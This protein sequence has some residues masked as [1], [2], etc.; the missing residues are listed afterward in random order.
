ME[1]KDEK[2][3]VLPMPSAEPMPQKARGDGELTGSLPQ[4]GFLANTYLPMQEWG[5]IYDKQEAFAKGT[6]FPGLDLPFQN[7]VNSKP[8]A[9]PLTEL[10][11]LDF[12][13]HELKLY[14]DVHPHDKEALELL[15]SYIKMSRDAH[16]AFEGGPL[17]I[18][19]PM[20]DL[21]TWVSKPWPWEKTEMEG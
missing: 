3:T 20:P 5:R 15:Q 14:L 12:A 8:A 6:L 9:T 19:D 11:A 13:C 18:Q 1:F 2:T 4:V 7:R 17:S 10:M 21:F 16:Q